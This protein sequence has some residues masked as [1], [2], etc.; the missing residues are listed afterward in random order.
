MMNPK[1]DSLFNIR[2]NIFCNNLDIN[3]DLK[4]NLAFR[5]LNCFTIFNHQKCVQRV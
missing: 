5:S 3:L 2:I 4:N 1:G